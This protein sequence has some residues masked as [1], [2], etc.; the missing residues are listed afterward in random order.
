MKKIT[1][2]LSL[3]I[4]QHFYAQDGA[5]DTTF[6]TNGVVVI[7]GTNVTF[8]PQSQDG[9]ILYQKNNVIKRL[10]ATGQADATF[11]ASGQITLDQPG[12]D[13]YYNLLVKDNKI[14]A[15]TGD[16]LGWPGGWEYFA[17]R[18]NTD[19]TLDTTFGTNGNL[20]IDMDDTEGGIYANFQ[21]DDLIVSGNTVSSGGSYNNIV[22]RKIDMAD[23]SSL[24]WSGQGA[25]SFGFNV[26]TSSQGYNT[27]ETAGKTL[28]LSNGD[29]LISVR[30]VYPSTTTATLRSG[31]IRVRP[32]VNTPYTIVNSYDA[33]YNVINSDIFADAD[34]NVYF[35]TGASGSPYGTSFATNIVYK[36]NADGNLYNAF[37]TNGAL[38]LSLSIGDLKCDFSRLAVQPDGKIIVAGV[39]LTPTVAF[40]N[41]SIVMARFTETGELDTTFGNNGYVLYSVPNPTTSSWYNSVHGLYLSPDASTVYL[42]G[43]N[44]DNT[45]ILKY[46]N[47]SFA[48]PTAP[49][50]TQVAAICSGETLA[51]LPTTSQNGI[52][53]TWAPALN[54]TATTT[55]T[56]TPDSGQNAAAASMTITVNQ[57]TSSWVDE[58][59][60]DAFYWAEN[61]TTYTQSGTY[62]HVSTNQAGCEH[63]A[64]LALTIN[65]STETTTTQTVCDSF[66]WNGN[67]YSESGTYVNQTV[68]ASGCTLIET[69]V[70]TVNYTQN[71]QGAN[72][73]SFEEGATVADIVVY[74]AD[75]TWYA[76]LADAQD[77]VNPVE[78]TTLL[79]DGDVF[80]A[81]YVNESGCASDA[82]AVTISVVLDTEDHGMA[83]L[84]LYPN[85]TSGLV[86]IRYH[87]SIDAVTVYNMLGQDVISKTVQAD[88]AGIDLSALQAGTYFVKVTSGDFWKTF[89]VVRN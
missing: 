38:T 27:S 79:Q 10:T 44:Y 46:N 26:G 29:F 68:N 31:Y 89:K 83:S 80:Y 19:G 81:V 9:N 74:P 47:A 60:C 48:Q 39:T 53:G 8:Y 85:P 50:F 56:F 87:K 54:N 41:E 55:Y 20:E 32:G 51:A 4:A 86:N 59:S 40:Q 88:E 84:Q 33:F 64:T 49:E 78:A 18:Y 7:P 34:D 17:G 71:L 13:G 22:A 25:L 2:A 30:I 57:P 70:L 36:R 65:N 66:D 43:G 42:M 14:L 37:G 58:V 76:N 1:L 61:E 28:A 45:V 16:E 5:A 15:F 69:L 62:T 72:D 3:L 35:L 6:G 63:T 82:F 75:V 24:P 12:T 73:Q 23:G 52:T 77:Q 11:G 67:N 21:N